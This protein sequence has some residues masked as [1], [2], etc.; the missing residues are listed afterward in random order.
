[1]K[2]FFRTLI[3]ER[4]RIRVSY[5]TAL[6]LVLATLVIHFLKPGIVLG[7]VTVFL[8]LLVMDYIGFHITK[9]VMKR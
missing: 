4:F 6:K 8:I 1:M 5:F 2:G 7:F 3:K 9:Y